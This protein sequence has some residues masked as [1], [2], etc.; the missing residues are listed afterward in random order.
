VAKGWWWD[1]I[2]VG[3]GTFSHVYLELFHFLDCNLLAG[4]WLFICGTYS[5][6]NG[7]ICSRNRFVKEL[8]VVE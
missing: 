4:S 1:D 5:Q 6:S 7:R 8:A 2:C 3:V